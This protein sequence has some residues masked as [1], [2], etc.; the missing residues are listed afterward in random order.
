MTASSRL[1]LLLRVATVRILCE[2]RGERP[3]LRNSSYFS[4]PAGFGAF[5]FFV[6]FSVFLWAAIYISPLFCGSANEKKMLT[7]PEEIDQ[8]SGKFDLY[9]L[10]PASPESY[11]T[12][13]CYTRLAYCD[14]TRAYVRLL[15]SF[16]PCVFSASPTSLRYRLQLLHHQPR[17]GAGRHG[18]PHGCRRQCQD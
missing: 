16:S 5:M 15:V 7:K 14:L 3:W 17:P 6:A 18:R 9:P 12:C 4:F 13:A 2:I 10:S 11:Q 1:R 8:G